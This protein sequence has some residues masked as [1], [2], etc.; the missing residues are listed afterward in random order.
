MGLAEAA[1]VGKVRHNRLVNLIGC[2]ADGDPL[3]W[4][5]R[6]RVTTTLHKRPSIAIRVRTK[7]GEFRHDLVDGD[8]QVDTHASA[9][10]ER[11]DIMTVL[12]LVVT[13]AL[14]HGG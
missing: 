4:E 13:K 12:L 1:G 14:A 5:I 10:G 3:R 7:Y 9:L 6:V 2:C 8:L 11:M